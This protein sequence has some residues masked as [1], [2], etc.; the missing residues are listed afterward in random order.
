MKLSQAIAK[1]A[2]LAG[3]TASWEADP[4]V[5]VALPNSKKP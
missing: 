2:E 1:L 3:V 4:F 5:I